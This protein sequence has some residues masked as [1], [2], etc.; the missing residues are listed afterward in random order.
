MAVLNKSGLIPEDPWQLIA[1]EQDVPD[2]YGIVSFDRWQRESDKLV[3]QNVGVLITGGDDLASL[4]GN[5]SSV[6][7]IALEIPKFTDGRCFSYATLL[8]K[9]YGYQGEIRAVGEVLIDQLFYMQKVGID[10][11]DLNEE[12]DSNTALEVLSSFSVSYQPA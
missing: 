5:L 8:R 7:L 11:F 4:S 2:Q 6:P 3:K 9:R 1:D 12:Q 10:S